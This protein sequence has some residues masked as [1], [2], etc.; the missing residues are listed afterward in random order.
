MS[1]WVDAIISALSI[2]VLAATIVWRD[3]R[4]DG[5]TEEI[6]GRLTQ[7]QAALTVLVTDLDKRQAVQE[8]WYPTGRAPDGRDA[9]Y[10]PPPAGAPS[11]NRP[12]RRSPSQQR[13]PR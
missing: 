9:P 1:G 4:R 8:S 10:G 7:G 5:R 13:T 12:Q 2:I 3:G 6:L 11:K